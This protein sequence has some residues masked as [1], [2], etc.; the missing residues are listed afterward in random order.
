M[1]PLHCHGAKGP[2]RPLRVCVTPGN[3]THA[4]RR[5]KPAQARLLGPGSCS[6]PL[7]GGPGISYRVGKCCSP[8]I[9]SHLLL[10]QCALRDTS[11]F[12]TGTEVDSLRAQETSD[13]AQARHEGVGLQASSC[14]SLLLA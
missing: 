12:R 14:L 13:L 1:K 5:T 11:P 4:P 8:G 9:G 2:T 7:P 3:L 6:R 10:A